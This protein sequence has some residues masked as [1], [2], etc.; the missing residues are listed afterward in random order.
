MHVALPLCY[1]LLPNKGYIRQIPYA[2]HQILTTNILAHRWINQKIQKRYISVIT[3]SYATNIKL[4]SHCNIDYGS[5]NNNSIPMCWPST[6]YVQTPQWNSAPYQTQKPTTI[7]ACICTLYPIQFSLLTLIRSS[8]S[9]SSGN[10]AKKI[11]DHSV[12][13]QTLKYL[14]PHQY[15]YI[16]RTTM[17]SP[18]SRWLTLRFQFWRA[19]E[20]TYRHV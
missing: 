8:I 9:I 11:K 14:F 17:Q 7:Q 2:L 18:I 10:H 12:A 13:I 16:C 3:P 15:A 5:K 6:K 20:V 1:L 19:S 4:C